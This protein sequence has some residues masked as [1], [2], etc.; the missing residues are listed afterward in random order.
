MLQIAAPALLITLGACTPARQKADIIIKNA[1]IYTLDSL[2]SIA[3]AMVIKDGKF[4][5]TGTWKDIEKKYSANEIIDAGGNAVY[6]GFIDAHCHFWGYG[7]WLQQASLNGCSSFD[8]MLERLK[9]HDS[10]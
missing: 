10:V 7:M 8:E 2:E 6:P 9:K 4:I 3:D 5:K 1:R